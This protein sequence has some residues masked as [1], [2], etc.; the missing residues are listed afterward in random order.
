MAGISAG[1]RMA[2]EGMVAERG[3]R[4]AIANPHYRLLA[5]T[6]R[7][8]YQERRRASMPTA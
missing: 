6:D 5:G 4:F 2:V 7:D 1:C 8:R 3:G